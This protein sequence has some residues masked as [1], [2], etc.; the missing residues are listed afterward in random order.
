VK[1][2]R[3]AL[4]ALAALGLIAPRADGAPAEGAAAK[5][6]SKPGVEW[7]RRLISR[8][9]ITI[10]GM[11]PT[12]DGGLVIAGLHWGDLRVETAGAPA[13]P[14]QM[15]APTTTSGFVLRLAA[16]G[17]V[18]WQR[19]IPGM[20]WAPAVAVQP[21]GA[22]V[23]AGISKLGH[24]A[25][26]EGPPAL[27]F[28]GEDRSP[29]VLVGLYGD[30]G[31]PRAAWTVGT[32]SAGKERFGMA[33]L[34]ELAADKDRIVIA[35]TI[36]GVLELGAGTHKWT[37]TPAG[38]PDIFVAALEN[39]GTSAW[40]VRA[41]GTNS[42]VPGPIAL[43]RDGA[44]SISGRTSNDGRGPPNGTP[45]PVTVGDGGTRALAR[46]GHLDAL[47]GQID[48]RGRPVWSATVGG[49]E[50]W[51][52]IPPDRSGA[53]KP[54]VEE[55]IV[56]ALALP[57]GETLFVGNAAL[58]ALFDGKPLLPARA[59]VSAGSFLARVSM[60]G[61][62][63]AATPLGREHVGAV[64]AA[65]G[66][67]LL[68]AG[69]LEGVTTY[70]AGGPKQV[71][72]TGAGREDVFVARHAPDGSLRWATRL[73]G[74]GHDRVERIAVDARGAVTL[75]ARFDEGFLVGEQVCEA[76]PE[77]WGFFVELTRF[78]PDGSFPDEDARER[79]LAA[80]RAELSAR[81]AEAE[82]SFK[83]KHYAE[84]CAAYQKIAAARP[85]SGAAQAD[86]GLCLQRL[87]K[88]KEAIAA[89]RKAIALG[90]KT[91]LADDGDPAARKHAYFNLYKLGVRAGIP[92]KGCR[93]LPAA[94]GCRRSLWTCVADDHSAG[95]GM[96]NNSTYARIGISRDAVE[97]DKDEYHE[98]YHDSTTPDDQREHVDVTIEQETYSFC[99]EGDG[100]Q[101]G[102][103]D[104]TTTCEIVSADACLGLI[105]SICPGREKR[106]GGRTGVEVE[107][108]K[109]LPAQQ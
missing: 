75:A 48:R 105:G 71:T 83:E 50:P 45:D 72:M 33:S 102:E 9:A 70:P 62:L 26:L 17:S 106:E 11:V 47:V 4:I 14:P 16:D 109:L 89:N 42:D 30:D 92:K 56:G 21:D 52:L 98:R 2:G 22:I 74:R 78:A 12:A 5:T 24:K 19:S 38:G 54:L 39:G 86:L 84:A 101:C 107:E 76:P 6:C 104:G 108:I 64:A 87:G 80:E 100:P 53:V 46:T 59:N 63:I 79:R 95:S 61:K 103:D 34:T 67:D 49:D 1:V 90:A 94:P 13:R 28:P 82:V 25:A 40:A 58:P 73:G 32:Y 55:T 44:V 91:D 18:R 60:A 41:G 99:H 10:G 96:E 85:D 66:G 57:S 7:T 31:T 15:P 37:V 27:P 65:P 77:H 43:G 69:E 3:P 29:R 35:G 20:E 51:G 36:F 93:K 23:V 97:I 8:S 81:H 88:K 68:V